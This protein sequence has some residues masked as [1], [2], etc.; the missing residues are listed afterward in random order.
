MR[1]AHASLS[2]S[3]AV[4]QRLKAAAV[5]LRE[6]IASCADHYAGARLYE[7][8]SRLSDTEL[9]HRGLRRETLAR[10][11]IGARRRAS[12]STSGR[13]EARP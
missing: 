8:L 7:S 5:W 9:A 10:D 1:A 2:P 13:E 3:P 11:L 12:I 4:G 6:W